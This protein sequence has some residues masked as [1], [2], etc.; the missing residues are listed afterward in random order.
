MFGRPATPVQAVPMDASCRRL[1][2]VSDGEAGYVYFQAEADLGREIFNRLW[3]VDHQLR[4]QFFHRPWSRVV[5]N[6]G[7]GLK[8]FLDE[9]R[10]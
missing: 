8:E 2:G 1:L 4:R 9:H 6:V 5:V 10:Q 3:G 7:P